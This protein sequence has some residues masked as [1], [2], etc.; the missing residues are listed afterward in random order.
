MVAGENDERKDFTTYW[1]SDH[2]APT[3]ENMM[4]DSEASKMDVLERPE[5]LSE[6]PT[7]TGKAVFE[8]GA[9]IGRFSGIL[10]EKASRVV[11]LDFVE[12]SCAENRRAHKHL[13]NLEV[14]CA[15]AT[16]VDYPEG[17]FDL[18]F[19]NWLLMY[20][21]DEEVQAFAEKALRWLRPGG[22]LFFRE[23]C[24]HQSGNA[25]RRF[26]PTKY[27]HPEDYSRMFS[28]AV[29]S[30]G[31][32]FQLCATNC[33]EAYA[34]MKGNVHQMWFRWEKV[35]ARVSAKQACYLSTQ[36]YTLA[37][38]MRY[39]KIYG[40]NYIG[41]GGDEVSEKLRLAAGDT[42]KAGCR[43]LDVGCGLGGTILHLADKCPQTYWHGI[44]FNSELS[45]VAGGRHVDRPRNQRDAV[46]FETVAEF[47][48]PASQ[49]N[50]PQNS[51]DVSIMRGALMHLDMGDKAVMLRKMSRML[52]PGG[53][54]LVLDYTVGKP[55]AQC[56]ESLQAY[57]SAR[58]FSLLEHTQEKELLERYF[59]VEITDMTQDL[60]KY[61]VA[62]TSRI[63]EQFAPAADE[64]PGSPKKCQRTALE[65][66]IAAAVSEVFPAVNDATA[67]S[68]AVAAMEALKLHLDADREDA[69]TRAEDLKWCR[70]QWAVKRAALDAGE[71]QWHLF[72]AT[73]P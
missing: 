2:S 40:K 3:L 11:A 37:G 41:T 42:V 46:S 34:Q 6:L 22:H 58:V 69:K 5:I 51:F 15:D 24:F 59:K 8:L 18:V 49:L 48:I 62:E 70:E 9:G 61:L 7:L 50:Y 16:R 29:Q 44:S 54:L 1:T 73:K 31:S 55:L 35:D 21:T 23:S 65:N 32:R 66:Q 19:T 13:D 63:E 20:L 68:A 72:V 56:S 14:V 17:S 60:K 26:N 10:A 64:I 53:K 30:D 71:L 25:K 39:E 36:Q 67:S 47:G 57:C 52:R 43:G 12:A 38:L 27:R 28:G 4:L 33:V 45:A